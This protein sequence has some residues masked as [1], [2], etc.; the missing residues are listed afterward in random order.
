MDIKIVTEGKVEEAP[1]EAEAFKS[2]TAQGQLI[3]QT[4]KILHSVPLHLARPHIYSGL[5]GNLIRLACGQG[6]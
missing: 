6:H 1:K 4:Q 2:E 3:F 5:Q